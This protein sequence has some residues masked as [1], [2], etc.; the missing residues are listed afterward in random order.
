MKKGDI[1]IIGME[2]MGRNLALNFE[3]NGYTVVVFNRTGEK[4][5]AFVETQGKGK[6][7]IPT[8]EISDFVANLERPRKIMLM[9]KEGQP[10]DDFIS[11][12]VPI[13]DK[14]DLI[15]DGGNSFFKDTIRRSNQLS[16][17]GILFI[18]TGVSGGEE[19]ALKGPAIMPGGQFEAYK[20]VEEMF[21]KI[22]AKA[23]DGQP[24]VT[25]IGPDGAGHYV[26]MVHNGIEYGDMQL[27]G[28]CCWFF[29]NGFGMSS[30]EIA[31]IMS[32]WNGENDILRSYLIQITGDLMKEKHKEKPD[33]YLVD[34]VADITR[35]KG[36]GTWTVQSALE[37]LVPVPTIAS[38]VFSREMSQDKDIRLKVSSM[39][40]LDI[41][42]KF[43]GSKKNIIKVAHDA[44]YIAK[45]SSYAQ[46]LALLKS[47]S[48]FYKWNLK[49]GEI[50]KIWRA[51]CIIRAQFLDEITNAY[52][53]NPELPNL[54]VDKNFSEFVIKNI[55]K[56]AKFIEIAHKAGVP[57][58]AFANSYDYIL[59]ITSPIMF[60]AQ[61]SALQR[62]YF[63]AHGYFK[64]KSIDNPEIL[65]TED[66]RE[67]EFHTEWLIEG[68]P[69]KEVTK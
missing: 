50:A 62:D 17:K 49:L 33:E 24:C 6:N 21:K 10:V 8:Y 35:M 67:R 48:E 15:I 41:K 22:S 1:G 28:E 46:G 65:K 14:G 23:Y 68:R 61:V 39:L 7:I 34:I 27:I 36:T 32:Q 26:K 51:G 40:K 12:L 63:G 42:E 60:S 57:V 29:K 52:K 31:E 54:L 30:G 4:T 20:L 37:L 25:Y 66:G 44:L 64:I 19:G 38:A 2:V 69:E 43:K 11:K 3:R 47:A 56:L 9:V 58:P 59:Q 55:K 53:E 13:L 18:G 16:E 45:I 5:K